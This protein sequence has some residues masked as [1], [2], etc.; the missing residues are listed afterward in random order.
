[1]VDKY[2]A[3]D[4]TVVHTSVKYLLSLTQKISLHLSLTFETLGSILQP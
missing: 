2:L 4:I 1:M 3:Q